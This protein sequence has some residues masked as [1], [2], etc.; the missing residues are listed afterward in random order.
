MLGIP[1]PPIFV[2]EDKDGIWELID[3]L[4]RIST[5]ISFFGVLKEN[6]TVSD[7][8]NH[9]SDDDTEEELTNINKWTLDAGTLVA[10]LAGYNVDTLP[11]KYIINLKR[12]VCRVEILNGENNTAIKDKL[13]R[14]LNGYEE[15]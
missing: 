12:T 5:I 7:S 15:R 2:A 1:I 6:L 10:A 4:Q 8:A 11:K 9:N 13:F 14:K 3:G